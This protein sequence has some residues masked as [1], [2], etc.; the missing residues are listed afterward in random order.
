[1]IKDLA[2]LVRNGIITLDD[3]LDESIRLQVAE[4]LQK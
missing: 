2:R 4:E 3:I 1:M